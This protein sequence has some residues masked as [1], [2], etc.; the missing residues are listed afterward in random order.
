MRLADIDHPRHAQLIDARA[1]PI[2][3]D[4]LLTQGAMNGLELKMR[5]ARELARTGSMKSQPWVTRMAAKTAS[6]GFGNLLEGRYKPDRPLARCIAEPVLNQLRM[7]VRVLQTLGERAL[8]GGSHSLH[9]RR[10][11]P[12][13]TGEL[14]MMLGY[15]LPH[16]KRSLVLVH[17]S[18]PGPLMTV[19][20]PGPRG[21]PAGSCGTASAYES[22]FETSVR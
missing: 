21:Q 2:A 9:A 8:V 10:K 16:G 17:V 5:P 7:R 13:L 22:A 4:P 18:L 3:P 1:E 19:P 14:R 12:P 6:P 20:A 11:V 15:L